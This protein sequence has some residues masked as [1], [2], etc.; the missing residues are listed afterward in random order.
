MHHLEAWNEAVCAGAW[1]TLAARLGE[2]LRRALD[3]EHWAAFQRSFERMVTLLRESAPAARP[4]RRRR[5][6]LLGGDVHHAYVAEV[7]LAPASACTAAS[8][9]SCARRFATRWH[10]VRA[11]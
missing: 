7:A 8:T 9:R 5:S 6:S 1:G 2:R 10:L 4:R 3:L 11:P